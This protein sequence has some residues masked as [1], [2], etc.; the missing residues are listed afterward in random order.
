MLGS[1]LISKDPLGDQE[2]K[3]FEGLLPRSKFGLSE[4]NSQGHRGGFDENGPGAGSRS[5]AWFN[6]LG[7]FLNVCIFSLAKW[8][9]S[10]DTWIVGFRLLKD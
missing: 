5:I 7:L 10:E 4:L 3:V 1:F 6:G 9:S 2:D 8:P